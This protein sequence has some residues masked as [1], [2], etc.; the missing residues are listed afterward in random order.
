MSLSQMSLVPLSSIPVSE[1]VAD[2][3]CALHLCVWSG[4]QSHREGEE[5]H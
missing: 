1:I 4:V 3:D 2:I 5:R